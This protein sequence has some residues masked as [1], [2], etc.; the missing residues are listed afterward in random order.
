MLITPK[1]RDNPE[2]KKCGKNL[3]SETIGRK[4]G[5]LKSEPKNLWGPK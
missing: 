1:V 3:F 2:A 5:I 4:N